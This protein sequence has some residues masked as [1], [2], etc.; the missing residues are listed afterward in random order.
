MR[1]LILL[2]WFVSPILWATPIKLTF[3]HSMTGEKGKLLSSL[4][5]E[6]NEL[7]ENAGRFQ[8]VPQFVGTYEEGLNKLRTALLAKQGQIGR[9]HV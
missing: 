7:P 6:F 5:Q 3:W 1:F 8:V 4:T 2:S 9:A